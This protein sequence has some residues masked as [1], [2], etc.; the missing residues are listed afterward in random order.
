MK[1]VFIVA[2][3]PSGDII[4]AQLIESMKKLRSDLFVVG[5]GGENIQ[6]VSNR[7]LENIVKQNAVGLT[8]ALQ[9]ISYFKHVLNDIIKPE[10]EKNPPDIVI[11]VDFYGFNGRVAGLAKQMGF[12]VYYYVSPQFWASRPWRAEKLRSV[13]DMFLCLFPFELDFYK[14]RSLPAQFVGHPILDRIPEIDER[15]LRPPRVEALI[16]LLPG[17]RIDEIKRHLPIM[18]D[19]CDLIRKN[20]PGTRF[21]LFTVPNIN[22]DLYKSILTPRKSDLL[23]EMVQDESYVWRSQI[24]MAITA[25]G[26][27]TLE[28]TLLGIPKQLHT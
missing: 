1:C 6:R 4:A 7:F 13:V 9:K 24:D 28:N 17:S 3:D 26:M 16:G 2:G 25:S 22:K 18:A 11:T 27:E 8:I 15:N 21:V 14:K 23:I 19:A 20:N 12:P 10:F 5:V